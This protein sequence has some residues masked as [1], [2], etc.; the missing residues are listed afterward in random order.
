MAP[1]WQLQHVVGIY[2]SSFASWLNTESDGLSCPH[3]QP[4]VA[5]QDLQAMA[6]ESSMSRGHDHMLLT[7]RLTGYPG[8]VIG[9]QQS[10]CNNHAQPH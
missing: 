6:L 7:V 8:S 4:L 10:L 5:C 2:A 9:M 1:V 3:S